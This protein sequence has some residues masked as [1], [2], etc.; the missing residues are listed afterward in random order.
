M[1]A[2]KKELDKKKSKPAKDAKA[3]AKDAKAANEAKPAKEHRGN[4]QIIKAG[5]KPAKLGAWL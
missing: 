4:R 3:G 1:W 2:F 5:R